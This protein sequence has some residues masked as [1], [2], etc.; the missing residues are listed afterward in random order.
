M[1]T[2]EEVKVMMLKYRMKNNLT[3]EQFAK[4]SGISFATLSGLV[5][6]KKQLKPMT[7]L[8]IEEYIKERENK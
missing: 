4:E 3:Q 1:A 8:R 5:T 7:L 2:A 6:G